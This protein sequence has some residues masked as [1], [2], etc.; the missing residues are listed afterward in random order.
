MELASDSITDYKLSFLRKSFS[1]NAV[2]GAASCSKATETSIDINIRFIH[3]SILQYVHRSVPSVVPGGVMYR[4]LCVALRRADLSCAPYRRSRHS[5]DGLVVV[6]R[7]GPHRRSF[8]GV[9]VP[10]YPSGSRVLPAWPPPV[11]SETSV[12]SA[13]SPR[14]RCRRRRRWSPTAVRTV[15]LGPWYPAPMHPRRSSRWRPRQW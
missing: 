6:R 7:R 12:P 15:L 2:G 14:C 13:G 10:G 9:P 4:C 11:F 8:G 3:F 1:Y 5:R